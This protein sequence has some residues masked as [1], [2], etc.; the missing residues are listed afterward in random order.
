LDHTPTTVGRYE[1]HGAIARGG[2]ATVRL[3]RLRGDGGFSRVVAVKHLHDHVAKDPE[4]AAMLLDEARLASRIR[5]PNVVTI[6]DVVTEGGNIY[7][8]MEFVLGEALSGLLSAVRRSKVVPP[9]AVAVAIA[10][11]TLAGLRAAHA[12]VDVH[13]VP[14]GIVHR[15]VSPNNI[16][17]GADGSARILDFGVAKAVAKLHTTRAGTLKGTLPYMA[18]ENLR[19]H[20]VTVRS[21]IHAVGCVLWET[22]TGE[23]LF[24][25]E[26]E[27][28]ILGRVLEGVRRAPSAAG[29]TVPPEL[30]AAVLR[31]L[32]R[33]PELRYHDAGDMERALRSALPPASAA[34]VGAWVEGLAGASLS[35]RREQVS[36]VERG[37]TWKERIERQA[38]GATRTAVPAPAIDAVNTTTVALSTASEAIVVRKSRR[39]LLAGAAALL[40]GGAAAYATF[41]LDEPLLAA[42]AG[43]FAVTA[44]LPAESEASPTSDETS[45]ADASDAAAPVAPAPARRSAP[46]RPPTPNCNPPVAR[47]AAGILRVKPGCDPTGAP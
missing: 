29:A 14:L 22:L 8:I 5:H 10:A 37:E 30:D 2:M 40:V 34:E 4:F 7:L 43:G 26:N 18:P 3:G 38:Q 35:A 42:Q 27:A 28:V 6:L 15:D 1:V 19:G 23:R 46:R 21:D 32:E 12:A 33:E 11:D 31:A 36:R 20:E 25:G 17:V 45:E 24:K 16:V 13:G 39:P 9:P 47:D 41:G 44:S